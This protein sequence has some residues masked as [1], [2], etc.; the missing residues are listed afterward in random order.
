MIKNLKHF[1]FGVLAILLVGTVVLWTPDAN[2]EDMISKYTTTASNFVTDDDGM[3]IHYRD[4]GNK[5]GPVIV[6]LHGAGASLHTWEKMVG[7]MSGVYRLISLDFPGH[8]LTGPDPERDY[9]AA[10][11][12]DAAQTVMDT[13]GVERAVIAGNSMGGWISWR[14]ALAAPQQTAGLILIDAS[15]PQI[16]DKPSLYLAA[17]ITNSGIGRFAAQKITPK[18]IVRKT[19]SQVMYDETLITDELVD[20]YWELTRFPGNRKA[21]SDRAKVDREVNYWDRVGEI[22]VPVFILWGEH[23]VTTPLS[24]AQAFDEKISNTQVKVYSNAAH[25]PMEE[26]PLEVAQDISD[27]M[28][29]SFPAGTL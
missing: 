8:G 17:R 5:D 23:D 14:L 21:M 28:E 18:P 12:M 1:G 9:S 29:R 4:E 15:G 25:L 19:L 27:W 24:F 3:A 16:A 26:V 22:N 7:E 6:L 13:L 2:R 10:S 11:L 20:R